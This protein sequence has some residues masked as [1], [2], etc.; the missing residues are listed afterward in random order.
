MYEDELEPLEM[1]FQ[2]V[3]FFFLVWAG[4]TILGLG[5][6]YAYINLRDGRGSLH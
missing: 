5:G 2:D 1:A 6:I 3:A 4:V